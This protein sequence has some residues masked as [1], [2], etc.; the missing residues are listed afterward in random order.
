M[1][2]KKEMPPA[3]SP[4]NALEADKATSD[5]PEALRYLAQALG[6]L[7]GALLAAQEAAAAKDSKRET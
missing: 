3:K 5:C 4:A 6:Q 2:H 1:T 7:A